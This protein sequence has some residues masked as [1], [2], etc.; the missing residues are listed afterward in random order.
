[1][2]IRHSY[3]AITTPM[4]W[5]D[6]NDYCLNNYGTGLATIE[7]WEIN[8]ADAVR[9]AAGILTNVWIGLHDQASE[10]HWVWQDG[11]LCSYATD[12][13]CVNDPNWAAGEP[14]NWGWGG[15]QDCGFLNI[16]NKYGDKSCNIALPFLCEAKY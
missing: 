13:D 9:D 14:N 10:G 3:L 16:N 7:H 4:S 11:T 12:G 6:A 15:E 5:N 1:M 8:E 2:G